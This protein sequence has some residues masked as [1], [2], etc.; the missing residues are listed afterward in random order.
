MKAVSEQVV[1]VDEEDRELGVMAK[2]K[3]HGKDTPLHRAFSL[4]LFNDQSEVL[5]QQRAKTKKTWP[6][7]WSN[8]CCGHPLPEESYEQA[9]ERRVGYELGCRVKE[10][11][12]VSDYRYRFERDGVV[13]NEVCPVFMGEIDGDL[14][15]NSGEVEEVKWVKWEEWLE[16]LR[17]DDVG[18]WSEW[19]KEE[20]ELVCVFIDAQTGLLT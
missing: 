15:V 7:V 13:E 8:S 18:K 3:V 19:C 14:M 16:E 6:G 20:A 5:V 9:I 4:F 1:L 12:K 2:D 11:E 17:I 10:L